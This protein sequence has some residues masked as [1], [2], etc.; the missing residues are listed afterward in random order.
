MIIC[1]IDHCDPHIFATKLLRRLKAAKSS[2]DYDDVRFLSVRFL[3]P[4]SFDNVQLRNGHG[5]AS[6][7]A[8]NI[9]GKQGERTTKAVVKTQLP[10]ILSPYAKANR[11]Q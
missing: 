4:E 1:A 7:Q 6:T 2:A 9:Q 3:H 11:S 8:T 10:N 5:Q